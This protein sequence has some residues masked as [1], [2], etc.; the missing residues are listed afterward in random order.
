MR[1]FLINGRHIE[2]TVIEAH[3]VPD[4]EERAKAIGFSFYGLTPLT[5]LT[6]AQYSAS[7]VKPCSSYLIFHLDDGTCE[8]RFHDHA[9]YDK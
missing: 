8:K 1:F 2:R 3:D 7:P 9:G 6:V 4:A 5:P